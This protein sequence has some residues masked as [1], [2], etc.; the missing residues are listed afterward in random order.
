MHPNTK[1]HRILKTPPG[2]YYLGGGGD[3][4]VI[5]EGINMMQAIFFMAILERHRVSRDGVAPPRPE[6]TAPPE[7]P[8]EVGDAPEAGSDAA[9]GRSIS[10]RRGC[11]VGKMRAFKP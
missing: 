1:Y 7:P 4:L 2:V 5:G 8:A 6:A 11:F 9:S 10:E 3:R